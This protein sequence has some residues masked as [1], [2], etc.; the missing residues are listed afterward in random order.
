MQLLS[1]KPA[2]APGGRER[3]LLRWGPRCRQS[4]GKQGLVATSEVRWGG[5]VRGD[6]KI[7]PVGGHVISC[8]SRSKT[9]RWPHTRYRTGTEESWQ[10]EV[11]Q[12]NNN[13]KETTRVRDSDQVRGQRRTW[14]A[15]HSV[16]TVMMSA[17]VVCQG[18]VEI[19]REGSRLSGRGQDCQGGVEI[20]QGGVEIRQGLAVGVVCREACERLL[21]AVRS[22]SN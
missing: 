12:D 1:L 13:C 14:E 7:A 22:A 8:G 19:V 4:D 9:W 2:I 6:G 11:L 10:G 3:R 15:L 17:E 5:M 18:G 16:S 20:G 21:C